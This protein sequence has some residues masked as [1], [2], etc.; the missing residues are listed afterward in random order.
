MGQTDN[1]CED[2]GMWSRCKKGFK[3][4]PEQQGCRYAAKSV[5]RDQCLYCGEIGNCGNTDAQDEARAHE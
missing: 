5:N 4:W 3:R 1:L 2:C